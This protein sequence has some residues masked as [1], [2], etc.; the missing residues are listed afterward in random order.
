[1]TETPSPITSTAKRRAALLIVAFS[2]TAAAGYFAVH[3]LLV[4]GTPHRS[5]PASAPT[6]AVSV[7]GAVFDNQG[8]L[9]A[10][11]SL[12]HA[13]VS[14]A[15]AMKLAGTYYNHPP[16]APQPGTGFVEIGEWTCWAHQEFAQAGNLGA[17]WRPTDPAGGE[18]SLDDYG[19]A[20][21]AYA[22]PLAATA[23][24]LGQWST[25]GGAITIEPDGSFTVE[26]RTYE[27][28]DQGSPPCDS[29]SGDGITDGAVATGMLNSVSG[30]VA[31]G[32]VTATTAAQ[33]LPTGT[34]TFT[35]DASH[36]V[37]TALEAEWCG[38]NA[39]EELCGS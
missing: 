20:P 19:V 11:I 35:F 5:P 36:D 37:I 29:Q 22:V 39:T 34:I 18:I 12:I 30:M 6:T 28:C 8:D 4:T 10:Q 7:C 38:P 26:E 16:Q 25:H 14:C 23:P 21:S 2:V 9:E 27:F 24:F 17:C 1:M 33:L 32:V 31:T 13:D 3:P 15:Q